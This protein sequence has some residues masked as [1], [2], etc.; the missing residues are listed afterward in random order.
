MRRALLLTLAIAFAI[1]CGD[2]I[3]E[4]TTAPT[5]GATA[6]AGGPLFAT[7]T[8]ED[9][10]SISTDKDDYQPGDVVHFTGYGWQPYDVLDIVL[11]DDPQTHEPHTW[12]VIWGDGETTIGCEDRVLRHLKQAPAYPL[13]LML[14]LFELGARGGRY[15]KSATVHRVRAWCDGPAS[16]R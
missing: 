12:T 7:T 11:N 14:D 9:G 10:L 2:D 5:T 15:P 6:V 16:C 1:A 3:T 13:F 4:P 8:T